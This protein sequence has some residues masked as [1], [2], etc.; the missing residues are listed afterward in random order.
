MNRRST[1]TDAA[2]GVTT[3]GY[4]LASQLTSIRDPDNNDTT[5][6]R[7]LLGRVTREENELGYSRYFVYDAASNLTLKKD[8][9]DRLTAYSFDDLDRLTSENWITGSTSLPSLAVATTT[10]GGPVNEV[11]RVGFT[12]QTKVSGT[13]Y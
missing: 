11:Q 5:Y 10:Q 3:F 8:R 4:N 12:V 13:V 1:I 2:S 9:N 6:A 7:D